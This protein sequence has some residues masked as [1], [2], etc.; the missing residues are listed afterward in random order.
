VDE[1]KPLNTGTNVTFSGCTIANNTAVQSGAGVNI[2]AG[3]HTG[4]NTANGKNVGTGARAQAWCLLILM[5]AS[6]SL[7][8]Q[9]RRILPSAH[10]SVR[11]VR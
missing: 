7:S 11:D 6:L 8:Q 2:A 10:V 9:R 1:C 4:D 3:L 5:E